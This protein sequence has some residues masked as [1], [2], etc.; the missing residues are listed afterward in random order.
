MGVRHFSSKPKV[1]IIACL[2]LKTVMLSREVPG[3]T[4][5]P[6]LGGGGHM[7]DMPCVDEI[8][9]ERSVNCRHVESWTGGF[10]TSFG[11]RKNVGNWINWQRSPKFPAVWLGRLKAVLISFSR[12]H[13][14]RIFSGMIY[15][16]LH[17]TKSSW[18]PKGDKI[19][20]DDRPLKRLVENDTSLVIYLFQTFYCIFWF[21]KLQR[22]RFH[23]V[24]CHE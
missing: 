10:V 5:I 2:D 7:L 4:V 21:L 22:V 12:F 11:S 6:A 17:V 24:M 1:V 16:R 23:E 3:E 20:K 14:V 13:S 9:N 8:S 18:D 19:W 15:R